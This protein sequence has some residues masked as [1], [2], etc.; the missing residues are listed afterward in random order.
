MTEYLGKGI[1]RPSE[2][3]SYI[4]TESQRLRYWFRS[5]PGVESPPLLHSDFE[6]L[7]D[8]LL[9]SFLG[10][11]DAMVTKKLVEQGVSV[12]H[13]RRAYQTLQ[14]EWGIPHPF[15]DRR[16]STDGR[17]IYIALE[18]EIAEVLSKQHFFES[19]MDP[20]LTQVTY[21]DATDLAAVWRPA[22]GVQLNPRVSFGKPVVEGTG[23][24]TFVLHQAWVANKQDFERVADLY[25]LSEEQ[26]K[27]AVR[28]QE[29]LGRAA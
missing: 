6:E 23:T 29:G 17:R 15:T 10:L 9:I 4:G 8:D 27:A 11:I 1:Y 14:E 2:A 25:E 12:Q 18:E 24:T 16:L 26:V 3:A 21:D 13:I 5:R 22:D 20:F 19:V 28:Y 7:G